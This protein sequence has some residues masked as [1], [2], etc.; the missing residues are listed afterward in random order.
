M[1][2]AS[3]PLIHRLKTA[4]LLLA[5]A[6]ATQAAD[7]RYLEPRDSAPLSLSRF[8]QGSDGGYWLLDGNAVR[9]M[10][11]S[12][13]L[14]TLQ[15]GAF[16]TGFLG[17]QSG[18]HMIAVY[19]DGFAT[20]DG[21][22]IFYNASCEMLRIEP[23]LRATWQLK[24]PQCSR[25]DVNADGILWTTGEVGQL[26]QRGPDG[27]ARSRPRLVFAGRE[28]RAVTLQALADGG[29]LVLSSPRDAQQ[30]RVSQLDA[31][32]QPRWTWSAGAAP[33]QRI[34]RADGGGAFA[35]GLANDALSTT[36]LDAG[37]APAWSRQTTLPAGSTLLSAITAPGGALYVVTGVVADS[38]IRPHTLLRLGSDGSQDWQREFCPGA[39]ALQPATAPDLAVATDGSVA[40]LCAGSAGP[41]LLRR[42][43]AGT[44]AAPVALPLQ[45]ARQLQQAADGRV[46]VLGQAAGNSQLI[47]V[48][49]SGSA[50]PTVVSNLS[51]RRQL[52]L[53]AA[54]VDADTSSYLL[55]ESPPLPRTSQQS[56][57]DQGAG[58]RQP[59]LAHR[60]PQLSAGQ[61]EPGRRPWP[62]L[63]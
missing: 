20:A 21:G 46:L 45:S 18:P 9:H 16:A 53:W 8:V 28:E 36:R 43:A 23:G 47:T 7:W 37:G 35:L 48:D 56:F 54:T 63:R 62:G 50:Q 15:R 12:G 13:T 31:Q 33:V 39:L 55:T 44:Q 51:D 42:D 27:V 17:S 22:A 52:R 6:T 29:A 24:V 4:L 38:S 41:A 26:A 61:R 10:D 58:R 5:A 25:L 19:S 60:H 49:R 11:A 57:R 30:P 2:A 40:H 34:V 32:G 59:R 3:R 14:R 1:A